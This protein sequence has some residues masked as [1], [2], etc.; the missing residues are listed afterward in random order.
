M[1]IKQ[2]NVELLEL[3]AKESNRPKADIA[4]EEVLDFYECAGFEAESLAYE[5]NALSDE[6]VILVFYNL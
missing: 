2:S 4:R 6:E 5:I 3:L 1:E